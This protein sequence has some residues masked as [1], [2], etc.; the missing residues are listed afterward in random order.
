M[1]DSGREDMRGARGWGQ[2][3]DSLYQT[4]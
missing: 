1:D 4:R 3:K 2:N